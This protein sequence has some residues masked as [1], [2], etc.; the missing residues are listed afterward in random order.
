MLGMDLATDHRWASFGDASVAECSVDEI[1]GASS[2]ALIQSNWLDR[3]NCDPLVTIMC[4]TT[5][6]HECFMGQV[7]ISQHP[8]L[9]D[10]SFFHV[11]SD[12]NRMIFQE[13]K[14][15]SP[16]C[17]CIVELFTSYPH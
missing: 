14:C 6:L 4:Q 11:P 9:R 15:F 5:E 12:P 1:D 2:V 7:L 10:D 16:N 3:R 17:A 13:R 8:A